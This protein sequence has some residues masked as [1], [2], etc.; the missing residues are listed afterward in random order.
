MLP[1]KQLSPTCTY[2][3]C[4]ISM[5]EVLSIELHE[6]RLLENSELYSR[7][8][9]T[10]VTIVELWT[11]H[12]ISTVLLQ[13]SCDDYVNAVFSENDTTE[14]TQ[15]GIFAISF[16]STEGVTE[17]A[18]DCRLLPA[19]P[20]DECKSALKSA[21][22]NGFCECT[23]TS[24]LVIASSFPTTSESLIGLY[25]STLCETFSLE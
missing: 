7:L 17:Y 13:Q 3:A 25:F 23:L 9:R 8:H 24:S 20:P 11:Y 5:F 16:L 14:L 21:V 4:Q 19:D 6:I 18:R 15:H 10:R 22:L 12:V 1:K 2:V